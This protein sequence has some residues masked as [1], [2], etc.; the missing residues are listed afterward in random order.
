M[1]L[2]A[3]SWRLFL[4]FLL[5]FNA[6]GKKGEP[7]YRKLII[8]EP[9][10]HVSYLLR[11]EGVTLEWEYSGTKR[12]IYFEIFRKVPDGTLLKIGET[13]EKFFL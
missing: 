10:S 4:I 13:G 6:C 2:G 5:F 1:G 7:S 11:P 3:F 8:P 9:V 12:G